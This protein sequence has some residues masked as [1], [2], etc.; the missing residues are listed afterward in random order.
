MDKKQLIESA[1]H[2]VDE[3]FLAEA[4]DTELDGIAKS[5]D[6]L[7][8]K[9]KGKPDGHEI[10]TY[11]F[12]TSENKSLADKLTM[13]KAKDIIRIE[14]RFL[15]DNIET[16]TKKDVENVYIKQTGKSIDIEIQYDY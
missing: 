4:T 1:N 8:A 10:M 16:R 7:I 9:S 6:E 12:K 5:I 3:Q 15:K 14:H 11:T 13:L 2:W